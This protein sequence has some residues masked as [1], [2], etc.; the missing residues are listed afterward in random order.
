MY[1]IVDPVF[2]DVVVCQCRRCACMSWTRNNLAPIISRPEVNSSTK[3]CCGSRKMVRDKSDIS[4]STNFQTEVED[5][6]VKVHEM[7]A[8]PISAIPADRDRSTCCGR[9][10]STL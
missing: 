1:V 6:I 10:V 5:Q 2:A 3:S 8:V 7:I 9:N 4:P